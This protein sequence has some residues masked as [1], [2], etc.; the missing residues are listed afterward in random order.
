MSSKCRLTDVSL[1]PRGRKLPTYTYTPNLGLCNCHFYSGKGAGPEQGRFNQS[2]ERGRVSSRGA[3]P[4][5]SR[6]SRSNRGRQVIIAETWWRT[7][8]LETQPSATASPPLWG[9]KQLPTYRVSPRYSGNTRK[10]GP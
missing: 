10:S 9:Q 4:E 1:P 8:V 5:Q 6:A 3:S 7:P 2:C